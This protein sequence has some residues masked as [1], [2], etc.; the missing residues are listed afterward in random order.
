MHR[1]YRKGREIL[2]GVIDSHSKW[3]EVVQ[4]GCTTTVR[5]VDILRDKFATFGLPEEIVSDN[6]PRFTAGEFEAFCTSNG[7]KHTLVPPYHPASNGA[8]ERSVRILKEAPL[9]KG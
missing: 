5:T 7:I 3:I 1:L 8:A 6:G 9:T 4:T 2:P